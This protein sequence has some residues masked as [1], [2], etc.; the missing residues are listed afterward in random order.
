MARI[1]SVG[2]AVA[3]LRPHFAGADREL[4]VVLCLS[5]TH[6]LKR[7]FSLRGTETDALVPFARIVRAIGA[8][9]ASWLVIAHNHP[10]GSCQ[11]SRA[12]VRVTRDLELVC[13]AMRVRLMDHLVFAGED[14]TSFY[15]RGWL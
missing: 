5:P 7:S 3:H 6:R 8:T 13:R 2:E 11:P 10:D 1:R 4:L 15:Q 9:H 14:F 12:D